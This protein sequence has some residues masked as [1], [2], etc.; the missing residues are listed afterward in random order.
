[1][2]YASMGR[3]GTGRANGA[4]LLCEA[5][6]GKPAYRS[7]GGAEIDA[8]VVGRRK[9]FALNRFRGQQG[10]TDSTHHAATAS[11]VGQISVTANP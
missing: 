9:P 7:K 8:G 3:Q 4:V 10:G 5:G 11:T 6:L 2:G 1:M